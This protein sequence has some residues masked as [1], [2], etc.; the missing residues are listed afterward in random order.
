MSRRDPQRILEE[1]LVLRAQD[2]DEIAWRQIIETWEPR[3]FAHIL[4]LLGDS[5]ITQDVMQDTWIAALRGIRRL[6]DPARFRSWLLR[7]ASNKCADNIRGAC[8]RR[9][10]SEDAAREAPM[11]VDPVLPP[12][13]RDEI[14]LLREGLH[15]LPP[16]RRAILTL[17]YLR[18]MS[19]AEIA[20][21]LRIPAGTVKSRLY[22]AREHLRK[23][24]NQKAASTT[25]LQKDDN[26]VAGKDLR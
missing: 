2:G 9:R 23:I 15:Q 22:H 21:V 20:A 18:S 5:E 1:L 14:E 13:T 7:I 17:F 8:R 11:T 26:R 25:H 19:I 10:A 6:N 12:D 16:D 3:L 24:M 4:T